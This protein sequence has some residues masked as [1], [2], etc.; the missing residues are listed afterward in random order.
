MSTRDRILAEAERLLGQHGFAATRLSSIA[1]AAGLGNAGLLH[2]F[3]SK[4]ALY[5]AVL[6]DIATDISTRYVLDKSDND[7]L[8]NLNILIEGLLS[9]HRDRPSGMAIIAHEFLDQSGRIEEADFLPLARVV[10][11]TVAILQA[12]QQEGS[13]RQGDRL[14]MTAALH[15]ALIIGS[16]GFA[17]YQRTSGQSPSG[18]WETELVRS[19]LASVVMES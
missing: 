19:A 4:A 11:D 7:A 10:E 6:E 14:A 12:G 5:R 2:H 8:T 17:V 3:K 16:I 9:F 18:D 13:I 1:S 15:G